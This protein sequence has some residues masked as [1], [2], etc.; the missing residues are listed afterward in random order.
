M[1]VASAVAMETAGASAGALASL[2]LLRGKSG[3]SAGH[4]S[5]LSAAEAEAAKNEGDE[6]ETDG[7]TPPKNDTHKPMRT[8]AIVSGAAFIS[9]RT[10]TIPK[11]AHIPHYPSTAQKRREQKSA[12]KKG[13]FCR[14]T[15]ET[16]TKQ[17]S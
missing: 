5:R 2:V 16:M 8:A 17:K 12:N 13:S 3:R 6:D 10:R 11:C 7:V 14:N 9:K 1:C 4:R 15:P